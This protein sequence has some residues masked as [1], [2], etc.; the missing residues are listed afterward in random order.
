MMQA[1]L[2]PATTA[3]DV[4][5]CMNTLLQH[6]KIRN[7]THNI[8]AYRIYVKDRDAWLQ[9]R[10]ETNFARGAPLWSWPAFISSSCLASLLFVRPAVVMLPKAYM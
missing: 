6:N 8:L 4:E 7:A 10:L 5:R 3:E 1:H 9:V 2:A